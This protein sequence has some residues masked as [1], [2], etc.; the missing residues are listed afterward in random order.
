MSLSSMLD[1]QRGATYHKVLINMGCF[2]LSI[3]F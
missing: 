1:N 2:I 3:L